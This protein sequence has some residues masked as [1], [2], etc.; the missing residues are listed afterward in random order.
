MVAQYARPER[1]GPDA[2]R[3]ERRQSSREH[4]DEVAVVRHDSSTGSAVAQV[5]IDVA[6]LVT[7]EGA[8]NVGGGVRCDV[9]HGGT[10]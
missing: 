2:S 7:V 9:V 1:I 6:C 4:G 10:G 8:E 5:S 3:R